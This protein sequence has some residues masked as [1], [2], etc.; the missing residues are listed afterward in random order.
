MFQNVD[1]GQVLSNSLNVE[2][3]YIS[4]A[5][6]QQLLLSGG[7]QETDQQASV[8]QKVSCLQYPYFA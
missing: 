1:V 7:Q 6:L 3:M 4:S 2:P 8:Q 5:A